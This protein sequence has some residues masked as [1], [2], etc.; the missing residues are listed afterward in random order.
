LCCGYV[1]CEVAFF[2]TERNSLPVEPKRLV[3]DL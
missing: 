3:E 2:T 1:L